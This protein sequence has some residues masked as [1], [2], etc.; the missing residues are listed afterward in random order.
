LQI[1]YAVSYYIILL[2]M[3]IR[4]VVA[5]AL[6]L[7]F[8][9]SYY[10]Q[11]TVVV[12]D[13]TVK[14]VETKLS[15]ADQAVFDRNALPRVKAKYESDTCPVSPE[16]AGVVKGAFTRVGAKQ[17]LAF[18]QVCQ[19]GNGLG[20]VGIAVFENGKIVGLFGSDSGWSLDA[21][22]LPDINR[23]GIDEFTLSF[24]G[25]MHQG[26]GGTGIDVVEFSGGVPKGLGWFKAEEYMDTAPTNVW[27]VTV[28]PGTTPAYFKQKFTTKDDIHWRKIGAVTPFKLSKAVGNFEVVK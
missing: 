9:V 3:K 17:T 16:V 25:G 7:A 26:Q 21:G 6:T 19:T 5:G 15:A 4:F 23:N 11:G 8:A 1:L 24:G 2:V 27:R 20:I 12:V 10:G 22:V 14:A 18:F 28:K 13:P